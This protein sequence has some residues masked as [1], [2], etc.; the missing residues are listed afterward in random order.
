MAGFVLII[1]VLAACFDPAAA[2]TEPRPAYD[3]SQ[4]FGVFADLGAYGPDSMSGRGT[5]LDTGPVW[6]G[7]IK[8]YFDTNF[9]ISASYMV[10][11]GKDDYQV[12]GFYGNQGA[13][14]G[15]RSLDEYGRG[16]FELDL[17]RF[18]VTGLYYFTNPTNSK[19]RPFVGAGGSSFSV[20]YAYRGDRTAG[21]RR[22]KAGNNNVGDTYES[23]TIAPGGISANDWTDFAISGS[24]WGFHVLGGVEYWP[25]HDFSVRAQIRYLNA[26]LLLN[27]APDLVGNVAGARVMD[28]ELLDM[29]GFDYGIGFT[30][31][32]DGPQGPGPEYDD[33][34][35][36][37]Y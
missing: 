37:G 36:Y 35:R 7:G 2:W 32:F 29:S 10:W 13:G 28:E 25:N 6:G 23:L 11:D 24:T 16:S 21:I 30:F 34:S 15:A 18:D 14:T 4:R 33:P 5:H 8:Y 17:G 3:M 19:V 31:H 27:M 9:C 22:I 12:K 20:D 26:D 1:A